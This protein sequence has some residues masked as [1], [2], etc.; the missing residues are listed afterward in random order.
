MVVRIHQGQFLPINFIERGS[1]VAGYLSPVGRVLL[2]G[3]LNALDAE[4]GKPLSRYELDRGA[5]G[6]PIT[7]LVDGKQ[8]L[9]VT[10]TRGLTVFGLSED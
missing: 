1:I 8:R 9:A 4:T 7:F 5:I 3:Y 6:P 2:P 10:S